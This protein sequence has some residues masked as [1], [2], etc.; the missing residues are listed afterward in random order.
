MLT[1]V[2]TRYD[3]MI[4]KVSVK[5]SS[6]QVIRIMVSDSEQ[7]YTVL[8][9]RARSIDGDFDFIVRLPLVRKYVDVEV[10]NDEDGSDYGFEVT[11][12]T[13]LPLDRRMEVIDF[14]KYR[15]RSFIKFAQK[16]CYNCGVLRTNDPMDPTD[17]YRSDDWHFYIRYLPVLVDYA[18]GEELDTPARIDM[19]SKIIEVS[20]KHFI[21]YSVPMRMATLTH[22]YAH[23]YMNEDPDD[24]SQ[25]DLNGLI[26][27]LGLGFPRVEAAEA[28]CEIFSN[29]ATE[30]N[31]ERIDIIKQFIE[32]FESNKLVFS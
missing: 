30:Q 24:E 19:E 2:H 20:Q 11:G 1:K 31:A 13:R 26:V 16:F 8:T 3:A 6:E 32:D 15:L 10:V 7:H 18:T 29:H 4:L 14:T 5:T 9:D 12:I 25:A 21:D 28:W 22:E 23:P 27:Y 17:F